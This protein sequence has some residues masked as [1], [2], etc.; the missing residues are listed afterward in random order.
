MRD[1]WPTWARQPIEITG[2]DPQWPRQAAELARDLDRLLAS[3]LD[4]TT[5]HVGSTAVPGLPAKPVLDLL[6]PVRRL[7]DVAQAHRTLAEAGWHLVPPELDRRAWRRL[8]AIRVAVR[9]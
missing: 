8:Y 9:A 4:G 3:W 2:P 5:E 1:D 6:A 7:A